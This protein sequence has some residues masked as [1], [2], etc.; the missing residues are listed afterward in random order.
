MTP[1]HR[2]SLSRCRAAHRASALAILLTLV[3]LPGLRARSRA[4][5]Q[6]AVSLLPGWNNVVYLG[7]D[8]PI[9]QALAPIGV[10]IEGVMHWD[11][12]GQRWEVYF[13]PAPQSSDLTTMQQGEAYWIALQTPATLAQ[14]DT[15]LQP[16]QLAPGWNN[17]AYPGPGSPISS[18][19]EQSPLWSWDAGSQRWLYHDPSA[20]AV[21][22]FQALTPLHAYWLYI[23]QS[24]VTAVSFPP[25]PTPVPSAC[26]SY[27]SPQPA[28]NA[29]N[30]ALT[31]AGLA[32]LPVSPDLAPKALRTGS[33]GSGPLQPPYVPPTLLR[34]IGWIESGWHQAD[35]S[36][37][38]GQTGPTL[39]SKACA[40]GMMQI[41]TG[42][43]VTGTPTPKQLAIGT[44]FQANAA[45]AVQLLTGMW[46]RDPT[47]LPYLGRHDPHILEDWYFTVWAYHC[48]GS[49]C[50]SYGAHN[51]P[52]DPALP[53][54]RPA[55]N[56]P[57][58]LASQ[59]S[60]DYS[61]YPYEE[62]VF[63]VIANPPIVNGQP[64][65]APIPV[66]LPPHGA[67]G[68]PNPQAAGE[69]SAHLDDGSSIPVSTLPSPSATPQPQAAPAAFGTPTPAGSPAPV[70]VPPS[71]PPPSP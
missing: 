3:A 53:W 62:L 33:D 47:E 6:P 30:D 1:E 60:F 35:W 22:D 21:S 67:I 27:Q 8:A 4:L 42:M 9:Q 46:D 41:L 44:D 57:A 12:S 49:G 18:L 37:A 19:I 15:T 20:P 61:S 51:N 45:A 28:L 29:A 54:P 23:A 10:Q 68:Y 13:A 24:G 50:E 59:S 66:Q 48:F 55:Y 63:G 36:T 65:W 31:R 25:N 7:P 58:Q 39:T 52:D 69:P 16:H 70:L 11:A 40:Y 71:S 32:T 38:R 43:Q 56:S 14:P 2:T 26:S 17:V 5:A 34:A 64:L